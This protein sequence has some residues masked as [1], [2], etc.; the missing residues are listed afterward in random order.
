MYFCRIIEEQTAGA[1]RRRV[2][3]EKPQDQNVFL[4]KSVVRCSTEEKARELFDFLI[5]LREPKAYKLAAPT[6]KRKK[7]NGGE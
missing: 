7:K 5:N 1:G 4:V 2:F 3:I 6:T